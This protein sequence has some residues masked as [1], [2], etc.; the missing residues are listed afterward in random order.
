MGLHQI[1]QLIGFILCM[2][3]ESMCAPSAMHWLKIDVS[4]L[5]GSYEFFVFCFLGLG[6]AIRRV[7]GGLSILKLIIHCFLDLLKYFECH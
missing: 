5:T 4:K 3:G 1:L 6:E 7:V 2:A